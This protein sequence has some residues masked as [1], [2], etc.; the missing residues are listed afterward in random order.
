MT[1]DLFDQLSSHAGGHFCFCDVPNSNLS[2]WFYFSVG[3]KYLFM[4][5]G[6]SATQPVL[7]DWYFLHIPEISCT[8][9]RTEGHPGE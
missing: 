4:Y 5:G 8:T 1:R 7:G 9:V 6:R 2:T 3:E